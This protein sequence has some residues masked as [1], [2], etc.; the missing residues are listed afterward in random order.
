[1]DLTITFIIDFEVILGSTHALV[2]IDWGHIATA[3]EVPRDAEFAA[4]VV[5][6]CRTRIRDTAK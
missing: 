5:K 4:S 3:S 6:Q 2:V 1:L